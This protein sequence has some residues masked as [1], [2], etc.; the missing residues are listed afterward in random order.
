MESKV[1][2]YILFSH[3]KK[4]VALLDT[5]GGLQTWSDPSLQRLPPEEKVAVVT[6]QVCVPEVF[7][8]C[9]TTGRARAS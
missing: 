4:I 1:A 3:R 2:Q 6:E 9:P 5:S 8:G 7:L